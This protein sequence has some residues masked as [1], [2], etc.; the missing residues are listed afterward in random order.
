MEKQ[1]S[2]RRNYRNMFLVVVS[3]GL[4]LSGTAVAVGE[5]NIPVTFGT[6]QSVLAQ[7]FTSDQTAS[8]HFGDYVA[9]SSIYSE[10]NVT[11][12][13]PSTLPVKYYISGVDMYLDSGIC[14][15][16]N[17]VNIANMKYNF[18]GTWYGMTEHNINGECIGGST[19]R[20]GMLLKEFAGGECVDVAFRFD[21]P[22]P[23]TGNIGDTTVV[24][25]NQ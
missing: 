24:I 15:T 11:I 19:C 2:P 3:V 25:S 4:I 10:N 17:A 13:N 9:G 22:S 1:T 18:D 14:P 5:V 12:C 21:V 8:L 23:C 6:I 7:W 20:G 16:S